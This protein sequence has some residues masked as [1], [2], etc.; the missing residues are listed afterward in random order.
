MHTYVPMIDAILSAS[1][2]DEVTPKRIRK[3]LQEL[4]GINLDTHR[5]EVNQLIIQRFEESKQRPRYLITKEELRRKDEALASKLQT[6]AKRAKSS[7][8]SSVKKKKKRSNNDANSNPNA[9]NLR[10]VMIS[11]PLSG[12]L[13]ETSLPRTQ[14]VKLVWDYIKD[15]NLQNP[16][17]RREILCDDRMKPIFGEKMTMFTLNKILSKYLS[18]SEEIGVKKSPSSPEDK[19]NFPEA[20]EATE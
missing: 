18:N 20:S 12:F 9:L 17:D 19:L 6:A 14:I 7:K 1:N 13:G 5:K 10:K 4:F 11:E 16:D 15:H 8:S 3:A 2:P